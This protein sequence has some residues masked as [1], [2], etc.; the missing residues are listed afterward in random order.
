MQIAV[1]FGVV[2]QGNTRLPQLSENLRD[3]ECVPTRVV[4]RNKHP[5]SRIGNARDCGSPPFPEIARIIVQHCW[6]NSINY[7]AARELIALLS[8]VALPESTP[9]FSVVRN[10]IRRL[11][12]PRLNQIAKMGAFVEELVP[13]DIEFLLWRKRPLVFR[14]VVGGHEIGNDP[15]DPL[16]HFILGMAVFRVSLRICL[17]SRRWSGALRGD[18]EL[19]LR[20]IWFFVSEE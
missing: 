9:A 1:L 19:G 16:G 10:P 12:N 8:Q 2:R 4:A 13:R 15:E 5:R 18:L 7:V 3:I 17:G 20:T 6:Q 14:L 11:R